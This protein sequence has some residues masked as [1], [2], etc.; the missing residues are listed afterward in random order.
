MSSAAPGRPPDGSWYEIRLSGRLNPRWSAWFDG[1]SV[2]AGTDG[3]TT[4]RGPVVDQAAL[5]GLL[6]TLRDLGLPL[7]SVAPVQ[8]TAQPKHDDP[9]ADSPGAPS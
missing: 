2:T 6:Q 9:H 1:L 8:P 5:H 7:I 4:L 3:I